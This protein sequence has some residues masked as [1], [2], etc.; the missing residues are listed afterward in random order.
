MKDSGKGEVKRK[1]NLP[2]KKVSMNSPFEKWGK[3][4]FQISLFS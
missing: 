1:N 3:G 4:G 2:A